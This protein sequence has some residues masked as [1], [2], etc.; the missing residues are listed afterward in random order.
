MV[1]CKQ[2]ND[3]FIVSLAILIDTFVLDDETIKYLASINLI[4]FIGDLASNGE[5]TYLLN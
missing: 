2:I 5:L 4:H 1:V 3:L